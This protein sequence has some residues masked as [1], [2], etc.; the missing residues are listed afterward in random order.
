ME[1]EFGVPIPGRIV[2]PGQWT[3][4]ALKRLPEGPL[5]MRQLF[6]REAPLVVD[7]GCG[8]G[9]F[10]LSSALIR[11]GHDHVGVDIL[12]LVIRYATRRANQRG[13]S[14]VRFAVVGGRELLERHVAPSAIAEIHCYHPQPYFESRQQAK[15]LITPEF[16]WLVHTRLAPGGLFVVQTDNRAYW[17]YMLEIIPSFFDFQEHA[18]RWPDAPHGRTRREIIALRRG[19]PVFRGLGRPRQAISQA[20][21]DI[22]LARLPLPTFDADQSLAERAADEEE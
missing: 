11:A 20:D 1:R 10:L 14:N 6:G 13:L 16:L 22:L 19:L 5:N 12:P 8:N 21:A 2:A 4:T 17:R 9:R 18:A 7:L 3:K 15:R